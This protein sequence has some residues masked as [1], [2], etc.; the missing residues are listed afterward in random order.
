M[1]RTSFDESAGLVFRQSNHRQRN[2]VSSSAFILFETINISRSSRH[3][4]NAFFNA[5]VR[6]NE[7]DFSIIPPFIPGNFVS[8]RTVGR[9]YMEAD[10]KKVDTEDSL[11]GGN[12]RILYP[13]GTNIIDSVPNGALNETAVP[14]WYATIGFVPGFL[15]R[16]ITP[17]FNF[18]SIWPPLVGI[19][20]ENVAFILSS[21]NVSSVEFEWTDDLFSFFQSQKTRFKLITPT[22]GFMALANF[23]YHEPFAGFPQVS[24]FENVVVE[25]SG[26]YAPGVWH[27]IPFT[28]QF[29]TA[30]FRFVILGETPAQWT[31]RTGIPTT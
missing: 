12:P 30:K 13:M 22:V 28:T 19:P 10:V 5:F 17:Q 26:T 18:D 3:S 31:A 9:Y 25:S 24:W 20:S 8:G 6:C 11:V 14:P 21:F 4:N 27:A 15:G 1:P 29:T 7:I 23:I 16:I 2:K